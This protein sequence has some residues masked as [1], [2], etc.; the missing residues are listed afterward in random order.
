[1]ITVE[2][3]VQSREPE[4]HEWWVIG[5]LVDYWSFTADDQQVPIG[6]EIRDAALNVQGTV[7]A[8]YPSPERLIA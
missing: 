4:P 6:A 3:G 5:R 2:Y 8:V 7:Y 1:M